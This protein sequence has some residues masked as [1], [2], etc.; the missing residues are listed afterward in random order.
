M[1]ALALAGYGYVWL[2]LIG[3]GGAIALLVWS[4]QFHQAIYRVLALAAP[5]VL[6]SS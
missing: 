6:V 5:F 2:V 1:T 3:L 4:L